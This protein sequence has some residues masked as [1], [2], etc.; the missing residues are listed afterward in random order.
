MDKK[1][2]GFS[3]IELAI[4]IIILAIL[5]KIFT[6]GYQLVNLSRLKKIDFK[7][8]EIED[9]IG[10]FRSSYDAYPGDF[11][12]ATDFFGSAVGS[13]N[14]SNGNGNG[15]YE[16]GELSQQG[17]LLSHLV[18]SKT[19]SGS[20][21]LASLNG[22][23]TEFLNTGIKWG[24]QR[25]VF[26]ADESFL[27][28][29]TLGNE[30]D[31][32]T[33]NS[34]NIKNMNLISASEGHVLVQE[35]G[36]ILVTSE[37]LPDG[38]NVSAGLTLIFYGRHPVYTQ[39]GNFQLDYRRASS[40]V[41][42]EPYDIKALYQSM[43][44]YND[45]SVADKEILDSLSWLPS[46]RTSVCPPAGQGGCPSYQ[47]DSPILTD[48]VY[49]RVRFYATAHSDTLSYNLVAGGGYQWRVSYDSSFQ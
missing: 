17:G 16:V 33:L 37:D 23:V 24:G 41:V 12:Y 10:V 1:N 34:P 42:G 11:R 46:S 47:D 5:L 40:L 26:V 18:A 35:S 19:I 28:I 27:N 7:V 29:Y 8:K 2:K 4:V 44:V 3:L 48:D 21:G 31:S 20:V 30:N 14:L 13:V 9:A 22:S 45:L 39:F 36:H 6:N 15:E 49:L 32:I 43:S 38:Y 25:L